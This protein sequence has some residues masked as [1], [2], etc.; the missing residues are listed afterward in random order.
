MLASFFFISIFAFAC[1]EQVPGQSKKKENP[2][3]IES[4]AFED[5]K[6][7]LAEQRENFRNG[8]ECFYFLAF[9]RN[10]STH[11]YSFSDN[12]CSFLSILDTVKAY[13]PERLQL[14]IYDESDDFGPCRGTEFYWDL[15]KIVIKEG[16]PKEKTE[17]CL[18]L[19]RKYEIK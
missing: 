10:D 15:E 17:K 2:N 3:E 16:Y 4:K 14:S 11:W 19:L 13:G 12:K 6:K 8:D 18:S 1:E 7:S 9:G 5:L